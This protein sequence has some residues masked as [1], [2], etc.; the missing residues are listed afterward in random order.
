MSKRI[1][2]SGSMTPG[3]IRK[4]PPVSSNTQRAFEYDMDDFEAD[5]NEFDGSE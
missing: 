1:T 2:T 4:S 5:E 3:R